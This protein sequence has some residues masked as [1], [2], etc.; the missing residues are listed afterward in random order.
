MYREEASPTIGRRSVD[1]NDGKIDELRR[2]RR[3]TR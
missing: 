3:D 1:L 2:V